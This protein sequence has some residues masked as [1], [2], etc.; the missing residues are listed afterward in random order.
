MDSIENHSEHIVQDIQT[1]AKHSVKR[2]QKERQ[3]R[4][5]RK[6]LKKLRAYA[7]FVIF[8]LLILGMYE[9][10]K[11]PQWYLS[12]DAFSKPDTEAVKI[13][14]NEILTQNIIYDSLK[15]VSVPN[16]PI[17]LM[18][19]NSIKH[20]L[21]KIPVVKKVY[22]RRYGFPARIQIIIRERTPIAVVKSS[23]NSLPMAFATADGA[24]V[25]NN[26]YMSLV[27]IKPVLKIIIKPS[28]V[29]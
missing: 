17:F 1:I 7:K 20:E 14:N 16:V 12:S 8:A 26:K 22:V 5:Q 27:E 18:S 23:L 9:F 21:F 2:K 6:K 10:V 11:L 25:T 19:V 29:K 3:L 4:K 28:D 15:N 24:F 13:L